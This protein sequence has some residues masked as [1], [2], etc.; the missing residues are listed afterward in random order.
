MKCEFIDEC[1]HA[2]VYVGKVCLHSAELCRARLEIFHTK[3][4]ESI[5]SEKGHQK[6]GITIQAIGKPGQLAIRIEWRNGK[7]T[8]LSVR[9]VVEKAWEGSTLPNPIKDFLDEIYN[10]FVSRK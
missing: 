2:K 1:P 6:D 5:F 3:E 4:L 10:R 8:F 7:I 9:E